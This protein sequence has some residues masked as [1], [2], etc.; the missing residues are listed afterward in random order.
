MR[1]AGIGRFRLTAMFAGLAAGVAS[2]SAQDGRLQAV[3]LRC[4]H[5][6]EPRGVGVRAPRLSWQVESP[7]RG[8]RQTAWRV[9]VASS[10]ELLARREG[11]LWDSGRVEG[12]A[13]LDHR[14]AGRPLRSNQPCWWA[15][16]VWDREGR[17]GPWSEPAT[18]STGLLEPSDWT[19]QWI[20][21]NAA[22][23]AETPMDFGA[24]VWIRRDN[25]PATP[26]PG[27][28][29][30]VRR[31]DLPSAPT[32]AI[33]RLTADDRFVLWVNGERVLG[34][35]SGGDSWRRAREVAVTSR[36][37]AGANLLAVQVENTAPGPYGLLLRLD[38]DLA[39]GSSVQIVSD[40]A[41]K[42]SGRPVPEWEKNPN[43]STWPAAVVVGP[44]G[45]PPWGWISASTLLL[46]PAVY[47][48]S[49]FAVDRPVRRAV[50]FATALGIAD[51]YLNGER[52]SEDFFTPGWTDYTR[53]ALVRAYDVTD[54]IHQ[55][56]NAIGA[57]LADGWFSGYVGYGGQR[58]HY[59]RHPRLK[60]QLHLEFADGSIRVVATGPDWRAG[61]G[62]L[63]KADFLMG[64][65]CDAAR[66]PVGWNRSGF[67]AAAWAPVDVGAELAP[68]LEWHPGPPVRVVGELRPVRWTE[69][70]PGQWVAD[71]GQNFAGV[72]RLRV[73]GRPGQRL[74]LR[75]AERL[76]PDGT[77]YTENLRSAR[78]TDM[79]ICRGD[80]VEEWTPRFTFHGF[81]Y[82]E[83]TGLEGRPSD[84]SVTGLALSSATPPAG[85]F[86]CSD[87]MLTRLWTNI[88]WTQRANFID[89]PTD[90][91]QRDE[92]LGWTGDAQAYIRAAC[93]NTDVQAFFTKWLTDLADA[94]RADGQFPMVAP[95]KVA[96]DDGGPAWAD[97]GVICPWVVHDVYGDREILER[98]FDSI[99]RFVEFCVGRSTPDLLP[100]EK[101]H[102][103]GDWLHIQ[104]ETPKRVIY[105]A[106]LAISSRLAAD[107]A[108]TLGRR[109]EA[110]RF[111]DVFR[112]ARAA[113]Q[114]AYVQPD[115]RVEGDTQTCYVLAIAADVLEP[116]QRAQAARHLVDRIA[117]RQHHLSTGFV[118]TRDIMH[119]LSA[120]GRH[121]VAYRL[122]HNDT[123]PSW[124]FTIRH[125]ATTIWERWDGWTPDKGFQTPSMNSFAHYAFGAV[126]QWMVEN[127]GGIR[128]E[129]PAY[130][131]IRIEPVLDPWLT[132]A[133]TRYDSSTGRIQTAWRRT[134]EGGARF[135]IEIP[136]N[137]EAVIVLPSA[138]GAAGVTESGRPLEAAEGVRLAATDTDG[139][140]RLRVGGGR[141]RFDVPRVA[142]PARIER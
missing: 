109:D 55:G 9:L 53:R 96:G 18:W 28:R 141:Y 13:T 137:A 12:D 22:R 23:P 118:G 120:I 4:E 88:L 31:F 42:T 5:L 133:R 65:L 106:Y 36:L 33:V 86:E 59:G 82:V 84:D 47:L 124:G 139:R 50:L 87:P 66:E 102:C 127:I 136:A 38:A 110:A 130:R 58:D 19:A 64:E 57:I 91:P 140:V 134:P 11:D 93:M 76:N 98:Q 104:A 40:A 95:L 10:P 45:A 111:T 103:F 30:F 61:L 114:K 73:A 129:A 25:E 54:R 6:Q 41:W 94:Q 16:Q 74:Q 68:A 117:E 90:C 27:R 131:R 108:T 60:T 105:S 113:F 52:V 3:A 46:P 39:D 49:E 99:R 100:P 29:F 138:G 21:W 81:Q 126:Y 79:Y 69:P 89:I 1:T 7:E 107:I 83:V 63:R 34:S 72:V 8:Q 2:A 101:F 70:K 44:H 135:D 123:F 37:K 92:R 112:R 67:D 77:I 17:A 75:F 48:R 35:P 71:L 80:G 115:G 32:S 121:D 132:H 20:G 14:Y 78:A 43:D 97:A 142:G 85:E 122:L 119:V 15:V 24:A 125:G 51:L 56:A 116:E 128:N 62:A 26:P